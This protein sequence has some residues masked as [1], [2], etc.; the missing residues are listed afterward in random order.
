MYLGIVS[1]L[2]DSLQSSLFSISV[3]LLMRFDR[4]SHIILSN[5][6]SFLNRSRREDFNSD[7]DSRRHGSNFPKVLSLDGNSA[8]FTTFIFL[9]KLSS[10]ED[11][12]RRRFILVT[13]CSVNFDSFFQ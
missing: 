11:K 4:I 10:F 5:V 1:F 12:D 6:P 2:V 9:S 13:T 7:A 3:N 8:L